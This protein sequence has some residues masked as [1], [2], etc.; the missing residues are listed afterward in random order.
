[1]V[2]LKTLHLDIFVFMESSASGGISMAKSCNVNSCQRDVSNVC[3]LFI[4]KREITAILDVNTSEA[5][6]Q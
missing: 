6:E 4:R 1:V 2:R 5:E 3:E